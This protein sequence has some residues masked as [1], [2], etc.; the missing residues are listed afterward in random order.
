MFLKIRTNEFVDRRLIKDIIIILIA[1]PR[2]SKARSE[3]L[4]SADWE[5]DFLHD[6][7]SYYQQLSSEKVFQSIM[8]RLNSSM[9]LIILNFVKK[10]WTMKQP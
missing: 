10:D 6:S 9:Q 5:A 2:D 8:F 7:K 1:I 4:Y 3:T